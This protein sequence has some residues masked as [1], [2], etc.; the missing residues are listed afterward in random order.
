MFLQFLLEDDR[1]REAAPRLRGGA[2]LYAPS[3]FAPYVLAGV[4]HRGREAGRL[5]IAPDGESAAQL[6][7]E[8]AVYLDEPVAVLPA[9]S[10]PWGGDVAPAAHVCGARQQAL[11][12]LAEGGVVVAEAA[13]LLERFPPLAMQPA[14]LTLCGRRRAAV[15]GRAPRARRPWLRPRRAGAGQGRVRRPRRHRRRLPVGRRTGAGG[16]LGRRG[17]VAAPL[18]GVLA[19]H[20]RAAG[21]LRGAHGRRGRSGTGGLPAGAAA[22]PGRRAARSAGDRAAAHRCARRVGPAVAG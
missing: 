13:A 5:V 8:L 7:E 12:A 19:A 10:V 14:P 17:G 18:L 4:L 11:Q 1:Y 9:R 6:A 3:F 22:G 21:A 2:A 20:H 16:V 15:R